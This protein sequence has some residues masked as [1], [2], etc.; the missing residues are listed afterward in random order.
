MVQ[1]ATEFWQN[2]QARVTEAERGINPLELAALAVGALIM[3]LFTYVF[4]SENFEVQMILT[5]MIAML[6]SLNFILLFLFAYPFRGDFSIQPAA[7][8][9]VNALFMQIEQSER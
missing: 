8:K 5:A 9:N 2:R 4:G 7:F 3:I 6:I 1:E